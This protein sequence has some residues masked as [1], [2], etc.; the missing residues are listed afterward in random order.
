MVGAFLAMAL[1][2][3]CA[4]DTTTS[5]VEQSGGAPVVSRRY[6]GCLGST[7]VERLFVLSVAEGRD[8][9]TEESPGTTIPQKSELPEGAPPPIPPVP[10]TTGTPGGGPT[11]TTKI[12][13]YT[14]IGD[15][16]KDLSALVGHTL[17]VTGA[18]YREPEGH[19]PG[20]LTVTAIRDLADTCQ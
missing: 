1:A 15:A 8:F 17:E 5:S 18:P 4:S 3:G 10:A 6:V 9:T 12:V 16:G 19:A 13:T 20:E 11:A 7:S 2:F 14:L